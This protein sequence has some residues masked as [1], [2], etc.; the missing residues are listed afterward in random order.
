MQQARDIGLKAMGFLGGSGHCFVAMQSHVTSS[1]F[2]VVLEGLKANA[3]I[4]AE[5]PQIKRSGE[6][7]K[8][9]KGAGGKLNRRPR[10]APV[11]MEPVQF[12]ISQGA[13]G[14]TKSGRQEPDPEATCCI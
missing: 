11:P 13:G 8:M 9:K 2:R 14:L 12:S 1:S 5:K 7:R 3:D 6:V 10:V 4:A